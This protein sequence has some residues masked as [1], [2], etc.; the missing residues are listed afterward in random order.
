[1]SKVFL[2]E[3]FVNKKEREKL[4]KQKSK[5]IWFTGLSGSGKSTLGKE[6]EKRLYERGYLTYLLDGD[7]LRLGLN[8]DLSFSDNDRV[9]NLRRVKEIIKILNDIGVI[10]IVTLVSPFKKN[11]EEIK[12]I[13]KEDFI[14]IFVDTDLEIC[15]KR[16]S[17]GLYKLAREGIIKDFTGISSPYEKPD[18]PKVIVKGNKEN[19]ESNINIILKE[20]LDEKF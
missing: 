10:V 3:L 1:M 4:L 9:E 2:E 20:I 12:K 18:N 15:E 6:V 13:F 17:K 8:S 16:D 11:R 5:I 19:F 14:E 7:N